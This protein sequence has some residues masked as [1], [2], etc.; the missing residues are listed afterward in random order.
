MNSTEGKRDELFIGDWGSLPLDA[1]R[2]LVQLLSGPCLDG[3]RSPLL[4][5]ALIKEERTIRSRLSELFLELVVDAEL[6]VAFTRQ[7]RGEGTEFPRLL[8]R[9]PL[10]FIESVLLLFLR[11]RLADASGSGERAAVSKEEMEEHLAV[12]ERIG[13]TDHAGFARRCAASIV[14]MRRNGLLSTIRGS[15]DR[16][17]V[18]PILGILF[19]ADQIAALGRAYAAM[20]EGETVMSEDEKDDEESW[21]VEDPSG[22]EE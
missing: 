9:M 6:Q 17:E 8:R 22:E 19:S 12:Y 4:W 2:S 13:N 1:R 21:R 11:Q 5:Q 16:F 20:A 10:T 3:K 7:V 15:E 18:S 14:K